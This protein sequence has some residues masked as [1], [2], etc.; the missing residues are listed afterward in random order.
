MVLLRA[1]PTS[2][3]LLVSLAACDVGE[4]PLN[5]GG[6]GDGGGTTDGGPTNGFATSCVDRSATPGTSHEH[7]GAGGTTHKGEGCIAVGC[8]L[9]AQPGGE[10]TA[11]GT[12]YKKDG[13]TPNP[14][15]IVRIKSGTK[16]LTQVTESDGTFHFGPTQAITF[17]TIT[18]VSGC[19][20]FSKMT[21][22]IT[23]GGGNCSGGACHALG[24]TQGVIKGIN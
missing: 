24:G 11:A 23:T 14:G 12:I 10:F 8:H 4:V 3:L 16:T 7:G 6:G 2:V 19:P 21:S 17:P 13:T 1:F 22:N 9:A 15:V 20:D 18:D 5:G